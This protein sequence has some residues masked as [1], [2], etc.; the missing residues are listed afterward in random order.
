MV[1]EEADFRITSSGGPFW[2]L[3]L[4][5]TVRPKDKPERQ[6][7]KDSGYG[8][9]LSACMDRIVNHR[10]SLGKEVFTLIEYVQDYKKYRDLLDKSYKGM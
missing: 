8:L 2:D 3:E 4:L 5:H 1:I 9:P 6:E 10:L 7:F